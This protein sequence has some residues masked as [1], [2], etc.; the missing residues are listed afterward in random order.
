M[1]SVQ[2]STTPERHGS[3]RDVRFA[4]RVPELEPSALG[5]RRFGAIF[6][7][8]LDGSTLASAE[9]VFDS[10]AHA[11]KYAVAMAKRAIDHA[12]GAEDAAS[13]P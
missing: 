7:I 4:I 1:A 10:R 5:H 2:K 12:L 11:T 13:R 6:S 9:L 8:S 3:H